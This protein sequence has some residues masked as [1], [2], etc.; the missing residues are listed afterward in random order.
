MQE[1]NSF[2][3]ELYAMC[4][5]DGEDSPS[6]TIDFIFNTIDNALSQ[7]EFSSVD[8]VLSALTLDQLN[9]DAMLAFLTITLAAKDRLQTRDYLFDDIKKYLIEKKEKN[10]KALLQGLE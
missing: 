2:L 4:L 7:G 5:E 9:I 8:L 1:I 3:K 6:D 10:I